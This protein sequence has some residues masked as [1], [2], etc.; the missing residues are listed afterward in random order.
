MNKIL[1]FM[2]GALC[3]AVVGATV[4]MLL[5]P[6]SGEELRGE[7]VHRWEDALN[8]ARQAM[9]DTRRDLQAQFEMMQQGNYQ[10]EAAETE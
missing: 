1:S 3:G 9:E 4:A 10:E 8:E 7:M 5:A 6:S 2:A